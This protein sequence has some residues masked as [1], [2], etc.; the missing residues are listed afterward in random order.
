MD[1]HRPAGIAVRNCRVVCPHDLVPVA[2]N[3]NDFA[4]ALLHHD[5]AV[6]QDMHIMNPAPGHLP[7]GFS[8][9][10][11]DREM[12]VALR[13]EPMLRLSRRTGKDGERHNNHANGEAHT[14]PS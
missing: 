3:L 2:V 5:V 4:C 13:N 9:T 1:F 12:V 8:V 14:C 6:G 7:F 11:D 10:P